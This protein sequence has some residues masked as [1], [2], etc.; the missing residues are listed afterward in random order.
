MFASAGQGATPT[1]FLENIRLNLFPDNQSAR[2]VLQFEN[3]TGLET[4][5]FSKLARNFDLA[6]L[7]QNR[8]HGLKVRSGG[9]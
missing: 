7:S 1:P 9:S 5:L 6:V 3:V 2:L 8:V 4:K